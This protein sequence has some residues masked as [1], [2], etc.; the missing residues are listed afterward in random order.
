MDNNIIYLVSLEGNRYVINKDVAQLCG[1]IAVML[2]DE[3]DD[4]EDEIEIPL[5]IV[6]SRELVKIMEFL[7]QYNRDPMNENMNEVQEWYMHFVTALD[8]E[9]FTELMNAANYLDLLP[10]MNLMMTIARQN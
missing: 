10:L 5:A 8:G 1:F 3:D 6:K 4:C 7:Y 2:P 9:S